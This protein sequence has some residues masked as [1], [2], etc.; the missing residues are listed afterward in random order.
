MNTSCKYR[1]DF[2][3]ILSPRTMGIM[4]P[5]KD[6]QYPDPFNIELAR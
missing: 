1:E 4:I 3:D 6:L 5:K 2:L